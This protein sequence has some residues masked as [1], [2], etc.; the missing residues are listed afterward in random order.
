VLLSLTLTEVYYIQS[1]VIR[2]LKLLSGRLIIYQ[3]Y[4][5]GHPKLSELVASTIFTNILRL[6]ITIAVCPSSCYLA[7]GALMRSSY[8]GSLV[9]RAQIVNALSEP[10]AI[11]DHPF[12]KVL[13]YDARHTYKRIGGSG[14]QKKTGRRDVLVPISRLQA[15]LA[16][17]RVRENT[18]AA[19]SRM[20]L[21]WS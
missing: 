17:V 5:G 6:G 2:L 11:S 4:I 21:V 15:C 12:T 7:S 1:T 3:T 20:L 18:R 8:V 9:P 16:W 10:A 13:D 19:G 14:L